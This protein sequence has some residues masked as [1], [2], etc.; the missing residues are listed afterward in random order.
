[1]QEAFLAIDAGEL[2]VTAGRVGTPIGYEVLEPW[3]NTH[4]SRSNAWNIQPINHDG[5]TVSGSTG[6]VSG[7][8]GVVNSFFVIDPF[9]NNPDDEYG[10][11]GAV[12]A[13]LGDVDLSLSAIYSEEGDAADLLE[14]N[15][16]LAG[17][18]GSCNYALEGT[19]FDGDI[20]TDGSSGTYG[21][22]L[23][24]EIWDV[25]GYFDVHNGP[26]SGGLRAS[27]TDIEGGFGLGS[28]F[29][30]GGFKAENDIWS[31]SLNRWLRD[32]GRRD[33]SCRVTVTTARIC[34]STTTTIR[35][36]GRRTRT[37]IWCRP[38]SSGC[39]NT[40]SRTASGSVRCRPDPQRGSPHCGGPLFRWGARISPG[41]S[42]AVARVAGG[43]PFLNRPDHD[44]AGVPGSPK[45]AP[46][47]RLNR[48]SA[49][50]HDSGGP[51]WLLQHR[52]YAV[53]L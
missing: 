31:V 17:V 35:L 44:T 3:G 9:A 19:Y 33:C 24:I 53:S 15:G 11:I 36:V 32:R 25:T 22:D 23:D 18:V 38:R 34:R 49:L 6:D 46:E 52:N 41:G 28:S 43:F 13:A 39:R 16:I 30:D 12:G 27:Y 29:S 7:M 5:L 45:R 48:F 26:W 14:I 10:I 42:Q 21:D 47:P 40:V 51:V 4:I 1:M 37:S 2:T 20:D 50:D 8:I